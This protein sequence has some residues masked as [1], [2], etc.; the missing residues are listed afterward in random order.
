MLGLVPLIATH[1]SEPN[2]G[3]QNGQ[4][5]LFTYKCC[6]LINFANSLDTDQAS[7]NI[8]PDVDHI[9]LTLRWYIFM[10]EFF[11]KVDFEKNQQTAT[12]NEKFPWGA[13]S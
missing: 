6:L 1:V 8:E 10:K 3:I 2:F 13:K 5:P 9:C 11:E 7:Q 12:E 4:Y